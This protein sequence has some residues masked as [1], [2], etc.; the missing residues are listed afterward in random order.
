MMRNPRVTGTDKEIYEVLLDDGSKIECTGNHKFILRDGSKVEAINLQ[1]GDSLNV[2][3]KWKTTWNE[4]LKDKCNSKSS[5]YWQLHTGK[6]LK[7][8]HSFVVEQLTNT[9]IKSGNVVH[10]KDFNSLNNNINNL[11]IMTKKQHDD[12]HNISGDNNPMRKWYPNASHEEKNRYRNN[13]SKATSGCLNGR[14]INIS[15]EEILLLM[16][17]YINNTKLPLTSARWKKQAKTLG[18]PQHFTNFRGSISDLISVANIECG[19]NIVC[20]KENSFVNR[21]YVRFL[22]IKNDSDL[23]V[24]FEN[25]HIVVYKKCEG[26]GE[27]IVNSWNRRE[28]C[29]CKSCSMKKSL[30]MMNKASSEKHTSIRIN[31]LQ[32]SIDLFVK[33]VDN[34]KYIPS[35]EDLLAEFNKNDIKDFRTVGYD[36]YIKFLQTINEQYSVCINTRKLDDKDYSFE[37]AKE[38]IDNG[39][40]YNHK[41]VSVTKRGIETV[42]NG[43]VD[44]YHNFGIILDKKNTKSGREKLEMVFTPQCGEI[45]MSEYNS[46]ILMLVNLKS[47]IDNP[48]TDNATFNKVT[49]E[50]Y[51][52][53]ATRLIDDMIDLEIEKVNQII[54]KVKQDP[55]PDEVKAVELNLWLKI[56][57]CYQKGRRTGL[58]VTSL[59]DMIAMMGIQYGSQEAVNFAEEVFKLFQQFTYD[60]NAELAKER[61]SFPVWNWEKEKNSHYIKILPKEVQDKIKKQGRRNIASNTCAPAGS[62]SILAQSS[63]GIEPIFMR[64][65]TR[66][67]KM[68]Q[69]EINNGT[70]EAYIDSTGIKWISYEVLHHGLEQWK[71]MYPDKH[72]SESPYVNSEAGELD[73]RFRVRLQG[74]IQR[75]CDHSLSS[76]CNLHKDIS[77]QEVSDLYMMAHEHKCKGITIYRDGCRQGVLTATEPK[78]EDVKQL[79]TI[80]DNHAPRRQLVLPCEIVY[81]NIKN[82][83]TK[84]TDKWIFIVGL[85]EGR[86]YEI[87]GGKKSNIEIPKKYKTGWLI[88]NG[89]NKDGIRTYDLYLGT[90]EDT[91]ER[92]IIKDIANEF[93]KTTSSYTRIISTLLRHGVP[94]NI[95]CEQLLKDSGSDMFSFE[96]G[97]QRVLKKYIKDGLKSGECC[98][99]CGGEMIYSGG[100]STCSSCG[101]SKCK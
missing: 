48:F 52:R 15:N 68:T 6:S 27:S 10:H 14:Y 25:N 88:K 47:F 38:M 78:K 28:I 90:L 4:I 31:K 96:K 1:V 75:Y 42:Y 87:F 83:E 11:E 80:K 73:W 23:D 99:S 9:N 45:L 12:Y 92:M 100:C 82:I 34:N 39:L 85:L 51:T 30:Y 22:E 44:N 74:I 98:S 101:D 95:V 20:N 69:E 50:K 77:K 59:G 64:S 5:E 93:S 21:E 61:G 18:I 62:I 8:E 56:L 91:D 79:T 55:E 16:K 26:C 71:A 24:R 19:F 43:T 97:C 33:F 49:F 41:V 67:R 66:N 58:G 53:I 84:E 29:F 32:K 65:Y 13:M 70:K 35:K 86:P 7:F 36:S 17:D 46:C 72:I 54:D 60:E 76:T 37:I 57:D 94:L 81:S 2:K 89:K 63:S 40:C 3:S